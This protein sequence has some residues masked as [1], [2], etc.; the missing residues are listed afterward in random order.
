MGGVRPVR[1]LVSVHVCAR[2]VSAACTG[3][4][5]SPTLGFTLSS[6]SPDSNPP[7]AHCPQTSLSPRKPSATPAAPSTPVPTCPT[8]S[9]APHSLPC[10]EPPPHTQARP[11][12]PDSVVTL[13]LCGSCPHSQA[14]EPARPSPASPQRPRGP[15]CSPH[16]PASCHPTPGVLDTSRWLGLRAGRETGRGEGHRWWSPAKAAPSPSQARL[17]RG[18]P[19]APGKQLRSPAGGRGPQGPARRRAGPRLSRRP[20][21]RAQGLPLATDTPLHKSWSQQSTSTF[22]IPE[23]MKP[24]R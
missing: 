10:Q 20:P 5:A 3:D 12:S 21:A 16:P 2:P 6:C 19:Q 1:V 7:P 11:R 14:A 23:L 8:A 13:S 18:Q 17:R 4:K 9:S 24:I 15:S 22:K